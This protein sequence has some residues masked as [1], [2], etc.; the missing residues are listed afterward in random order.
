MLLASTASAAQMPASDWQQQL[1]ED[2]GK[3]Q[4]DAGF[5]DGGSTDSYRRVSDKSSELSHR[6]HL[7]TIHRRGPT[8][9]LHDF[10]RRSRCFE[11][12]YDPLLTSSP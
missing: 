11:L 1:R 10:C 3:Q 8:M 4:L 2:I 7:R 6:R 12:R 5:P 9:A